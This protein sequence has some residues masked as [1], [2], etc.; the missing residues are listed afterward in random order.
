VSYCWKS[1]YKDKKLE[2]VYRLRN[3]YKGGLGPSMQ[4]DEQYHI[5]DSIINTW[6]KKSCR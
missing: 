5:C 6:K 1:Y 4:D 2:S 3:I